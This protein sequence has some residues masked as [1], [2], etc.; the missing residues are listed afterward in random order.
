MRK[1]FINLTII[2]FI[3]FLIFH[4]SAANYSKEKIVKFVG[5]EVC[6]VCH[7]DEKIGNQSKIW[8]ESRH[9]KAFVTLASDRAIEQAA[10]AGV[11][12]HPQKSEFC[13]QCHI[14][15]AGLDNSHFAETYKKEEGV[16]CEVCH[17][18]GSE[19]IDPDIMQDRKK[20]LTNGGIIPDEKLCK[21]CHEE[22]EFIFREKYFEIKHPIPKDK[23]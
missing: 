2:I 20:F 17:G 11:K 12:E 8:E 15:G 21:N 18:P 19:Y 22:E 13:L 1:R 5:A 7:Q 4:Y 6:A 23:K 16:T 9:S 3:L 14:A 10:D